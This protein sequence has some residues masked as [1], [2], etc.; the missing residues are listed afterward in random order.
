MCVLTQAHYPHPCMCACAQFIDLGACADLRS[1]TNY[2][3]EE[4]IL[5]LNYCPPEQVCVCVRGYDVPVCTP[6]CVPV[7]VQCVC[8]RAVCVRVQ[9]ACVRACVR[10]CVCVPVCV[11]VCVL[12]CV[13]VFVIVCVPVCMRCVCVRAVCLC[14]C[15]CA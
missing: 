5:D 14:A 2:V 10:D 15:L 4:S 13:P 9:C 3:P 8:V 6:G 11:P 7:C 1:G 12:V